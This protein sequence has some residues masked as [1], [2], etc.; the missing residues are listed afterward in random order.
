MFCN[1]KKITVDGVAFEKSTNRAGSGCCI[2]DLSAKGG[3]YC[4][5]IDSQD[6]NIETKYLNDQNFEVSTSS[7]YEI[8]QTTIQNAYSGINIFKIDTLVHAE[9]STKPDSWYGSKAQPWPAAAY[10]ESWRFEKGVKAM[11]Y[12]YN[13]PA[14]G[15]SKWNDEI[16]TLNSAYDALAQG[17]LVALV[18]GVTSILF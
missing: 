12:I 13:K 5:F 16:K 11:G 8:A 15:N 2:R 4:M 6:V 9:S 7:P 17:S 10:T 1:I 18:V 14:N 3:G